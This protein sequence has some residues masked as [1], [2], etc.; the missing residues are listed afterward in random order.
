LSRDMLPRGR[1]AAQSFAASPPPSRTIGNFLCFANPLP[2]G[3]G[4]SAQHN[5]C[6]L[7]FVMQKDVMECRFEDCG[8]RAQAKGLCPLHYYRFRRSGDLLAPK[9]SPGP[10]CDP[11]KA[12]VQSV[13]GLVATHPGA[14]LEGLPPASNDGRGEGNE[15]PAGLHRGGEPSQRIN[16]HFGI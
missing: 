3:R 13:F 12:V 2:G 7:A 8:K 4:L 5:D 16:Q 6:Q 9:R 1:G 14:V 11:M 10:K 15:S